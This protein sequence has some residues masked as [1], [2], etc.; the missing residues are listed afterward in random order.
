MRALIMV[1][2]IGLVHVGG[3]ARAADTTFIL[4]ASVPGSTAG[5][6]QFGWLDGASS[7]LDAADVPEPP[8]PPGPYL[9]AGFDIPGVANPDRWRRDLRATADFTVDGRETWELTLMASSLPAECTLTV[10][11]GIGD[12]TGLLLL[13]SGAHADTLALP[14]TISFPLDGEARLFIEVVEEALP[15]RPTTWGAA[16]C[17]Y[18]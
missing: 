14:A 17:T 9:A 13:F 2:A 15:T 4:E 1:L 6:H 5:E 18:R 16:K 12:H 3:A 10:T 8:L 7:G 11:A